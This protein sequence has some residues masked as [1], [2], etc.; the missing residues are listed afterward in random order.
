MGIWSSMIQPFIG[1]W[2]SMMYAARRQFE[3]PST[4]H[5]Q[6]MYVQRISSY[7]LLWA[8]YNNSMFD[9]TARFLSSGSWQNSLFWPASGGWQVYKSNYNLYRNIRMIY[10]PVTRLVDF[11]AG[12]VYPG[13]LS[14]DG[15]SLPDGIPLA[16]PFAKDTDPVLKDAIAQFWQWSNWQAKK[17]VLVRFGAALGNVLVE[18]I[19]DVERGKVTAEIQWPGFVRDLE[20][21]AAGNVKRYSLEYAVWNLD[22]GSYIYRKDVD[23]DQICYYRN[24]EPYDYG[25]GAIL[26]NPYGFV[27]AVWIKHIDVGSDYGSPAIAGSFGKIDELNNLASHAH[28]QIHRVIG[29]PAVIWSDA[30]ITKLF[31]ADANKSRG[32]TSDFEK[33]AQE[34]ENL[35][36]LKGPAGGSV[37]S[38][39]GQLSL[40]DTALYMDRL[41][42]E[43]ESD[44]PELSFYQKLRDMSS[45][46]GP[47]A[48]RLSGDVASRVIDAQ[49]QYDQASIS[50]FRMIVAIGGFRANSGAWGTLNRQQQKFKPFDLDSYQRGDLDISIMPRP[51]LVPTK[52]E[53][54]QE[55]QSMWQGVG[56]AVQ[57]AGVPLEVVLRNEGWTDD[58]LAQLGQARVEQIQRDQL[59]ASEDVIPAQVQ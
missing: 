26:E 28:D 17:A 11:Y 32:T 51:L 40:S 25:Y 39:A 55:K 42:A 9:K 49:A 31:G 34:Q 59:L 48:T 12:V 23:Q 37:S 7:Q 56:V 18:A 24:N 22:D 53:I 16:I 6:E 52:S 29:A 8:Y 19:D 21:D 54:A 5:Q 13:V 50:L 43:V 38:L 30:P 58:D 45:V 4:A 46:T 47:A 20:L 33:P 27:P 1:G 35:L 3:D 15:A 36:M 2:Q 44:H 57:Q 10:N 14:E 41:L